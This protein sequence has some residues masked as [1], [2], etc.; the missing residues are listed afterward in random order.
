VR[1]LSEALRGSL[2]PHRIGVSVL[3]PG[4]V[5]ST[6][7]ESER[8]RPASLSAGA[9]ATDPRFLERL[10]QVHLIGMSPEEVGAKVLR[11]IQRND[12]YIFPHPEFKQELRA[13]F[14]EVLQAL[15]DEPVPAER[16]AFEDQRRR[17]AAEARAAWPQL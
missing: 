9:I 17:M 8:I 7:Y 6:I 16:L 5:K 2:L 13:L 1:G 12:F 3:C 15:P 4:L 11:A 10:A 14:D